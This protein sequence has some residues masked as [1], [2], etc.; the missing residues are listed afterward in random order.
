MLKIFLFLGVLSTAA[1]SHAKLLSSN[2]QAVTVEISSAVYEAYAKCRP[3]QYED[4]GFTPYY[5]PES[6]N[7]LKTYLNSGY[8]IKLLDRSC[9]PY[10]GTGPQLSSTNFEKV[11]VLILDDK[12][13]RKQ[14]QDAINTIWNS[15]N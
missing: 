5:S 10:K 14:L 8:S 2:T 3:P 1:L 7:E 6:Y 11:R 9:G 13:P 12:T 4:D 15:V